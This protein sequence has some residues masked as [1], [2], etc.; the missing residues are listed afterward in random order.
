[1]IENLDEF[2]SLLDINRQTGSSTAL[3]IAYKEIKNMRKNNPALQLPLIVVPTPQMCNYLNTTFGIETVPI[4]QMWSFWGNRRP[5][6]I[7]KDTVLA[8]A[9]EYETRIKEMKATII[10]LEKQLKGEQI[11]KG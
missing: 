1:M 3:A 9:R 5:I 4:S 11:R 6:L 10:D 2:L 8:I 7:E